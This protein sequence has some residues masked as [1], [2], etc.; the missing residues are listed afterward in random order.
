MTDI[1]HAATEKK[2]KVLTNMEKQTGRGD[3]EKF[4]NLKNKNL[5]LNYGGDDQILNPDSK[6]TRTKVKTLVN[7]R[8]PARETDPRFNGNFKKRK[9]GTYA[10]ATSYY[11]N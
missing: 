1:N 7:Y 10:E 3:L 8:K 6:L 2:V 11:I 5:D 4:E 9:K